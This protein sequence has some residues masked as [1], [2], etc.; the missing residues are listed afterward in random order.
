MIVLITGASSGF[1][2]AMARV[3]VRSGHKVIAAAR[4]TERLAAL[5]SELGSALLPITL[6]VTKTGTIPV[7][8]ESLPAEWKTIDVL[9]N[10]AG[11]A[12]GVA[13]AQ[14]ASLEDWDTMIETNNRGLV[15]MTRAVLP[16]M[17]ARGAGLVINLGSIAGSYAYPGGNVYGASKAFVDHFT[18]NLRSDLAGTGV[19]ATNIAPGLCGGTEFS[20]VRYKWDEAAAAKVY[21]DTQPLTAEDIAE[22][23]YWVATLPKHININE[24]E[25]MPVCQSFAG[26]S[27]HRDKT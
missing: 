20:Q 26:M 17:V 22:T 4:R 1:G 24:I 12:L 5:A 10:N 15:H 6:D 7:A 18:L 11:L 27:I 23:A 3:F 16:G 19:R 8:L 21:Q 14:E 2:E 13:P 25:M 9:I